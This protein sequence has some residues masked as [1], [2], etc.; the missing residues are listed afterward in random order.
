[1]IKHL[2]IH[3][4][5]WSKVDVKDNNSCWNWLGSLDSH[6]YGTFNCGNKKIMRSNRVAWLLINNEIPE[7]FSAFSKTK[8]LVLHKCDNRR[9]VNPEHLFLG[10][11]AD[12]ARDKVNK[13]R[14]SYGKKHSNS[15]YTESNT[16]HKLTDDKVREIRRLY[17]VNKCGYGTIAKIFCVTRN[18]IK[19]SIRV[20]CLDNIQ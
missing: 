7:L 10:T 19:Y 18:A 11:N 20:R 13:S 3:E 6:G 9:C 14:Q 1:M 4:R 15:L 2:D 17:K 8:I 16:Y 12:N 5:F